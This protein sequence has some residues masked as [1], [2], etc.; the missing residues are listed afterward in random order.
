[1]R[2]I[3]SVDAPLNVKYGVSFAR[4]R[5]PDILKRFQS[6]SGR[7]KL[8]EHVGALLVDFYQDLYTKNPI[9]KSFLNLS[10]L[11]ITKGPIKECL[12]HPKT[13]KCD[14]CFCCKFCCCAICCIAISPFALYELFQYVSAPIALVLFWAAEKGGKDTQYPTRA[15][16]IVSYILLLGAIVLDVS[17]TT[18]SIFSKYSQ[19]LP[20]T[21]RSKKQWSE[22]LAQYNMM[23][24]HIVVQDTTGT[25]ASIHQWIGRRLGAWGVELLEVTHTPI[26]EDRTPIEE[27]ILDNLLGLGTRKKW[28]IA[29][30]R[31][32]QALEGWMDNHRAP[33][34]GR[35]RKALVETTI[36]SDV[37]FPTSV[38]IWHVATDICYYF[39]DNDSASTNDSDDMNKVKKHKQMSRELSNYI[40]YLVFKSGVMLTTNSQLVHDEAHGEIRRTLS[41]QY[42]QGQPQVALDE[43]AAV[44]KLFEANKKEEQQDHQS[45]VDTE[46]HQ[47]AANQQILMERIEAFDSSAWEQFLK[48]I[49]ANR[50]K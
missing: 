44:M 34:S 13:F 29:S 30:S 11:L 24:R 50:K 8:Y 43:K 31:G 39:R 35:L 33:D 28:D 23:K 45:V 6:S 47:E 26:T 10:Y 48:R 40:M 20:A 4:D 5:L 16:I 9:R 15:D 1:M 37:D 7:C 25:M 27:F 38:L 21:W 19:K 32:R 22:G 12:C 18:I 14:C 46:N 42:Q 41:G 3:L 49:E 17:S 36:G 2:D